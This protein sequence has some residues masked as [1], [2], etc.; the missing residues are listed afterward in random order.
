MASRRPPP[1][2]A[3]RQDAEAQGAERDARTEAV[4][5]RVEAI[6]EPLLERMGIQLVDV[7]YHF[8]GR[9]VVRLLVDR[10]EGVTLDDCAAASRAVSEELDAQDPV[11]NEYSLEV[12]S[13]GLFRPLRTPKHFR[14]AA[15]KLAKLSL[16]PEVLTERKSRQVRGTIESADEQGLRLNVDGETIEL[17]YAAVRRAKLDPD[18]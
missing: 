5:A 8:E 2:A 3:P 12:S 17:P 6:A 1:G 4:Q 15:G 13:P 9:W 16:A 18:L 14:Q 11:P 7:E 10:P